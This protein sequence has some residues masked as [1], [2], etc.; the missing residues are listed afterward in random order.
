MPDKYASYVMIRV[1]LALP[2]F[3]FILSALKRAFS[4]TLG[5]DHTDIIIP[6]VAPAK[7]RVTAELPTVLSLEKKKQCLVVLVIAERGNQGS[8][9]VNEYGLIVTYHFAYLFVLGKERSQ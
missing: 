7:E 5:W 6:S 2:W 9:G 4:R 8:L 1:F 3:G